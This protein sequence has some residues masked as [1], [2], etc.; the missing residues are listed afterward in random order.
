MPD[1][2]V[3]L[4]F[5]FEARKIFELTRYRHKPHETTRSAIRG[6]T[7]KILQHQHV[8]AIILVIQTIFFTSFTE[9]DR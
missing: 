7:L 9:Q 5:I 6:F 3:V 2:W 4:K 1:E 8:T